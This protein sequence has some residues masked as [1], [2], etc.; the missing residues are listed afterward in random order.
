MAAYLGALLRRSGLPLTGVARR[1]FRYLAQ[2]YPPMYYDGYVDKLVGFHAIIRAADETGLDGD[3]VECGVGRGLTFFML[4]DFMARQ[5]SE[6]RLYGFD[7]FAGFPAPSPADA[8]PRRPVRGDLWRDTSVRHVR[9]HF[10]RT[11]LRAY[12][13]DKVRLT[14]GFFSETLPAASEPRRIVLLNLDVDLYESY[15]DCL[16]FLGPRV[17]GVIVYDE[18]RS[19]KWPGATSAVDEV[20]PSLAHRLFYARVMNRY[21][22]LPEAALA[23]PFAR[24]LEDRL[25]LRAA[26]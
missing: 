9:D 4:G 26:A 14:P 25:D 6:R 3:V 20:L 24:R 10:R 2:Y 8:S 19:P 17:T 5:R 21:V 13:D 18:Y 15:R 1:A 11:A 12:F 23:Q 7:S 22:S 16:R